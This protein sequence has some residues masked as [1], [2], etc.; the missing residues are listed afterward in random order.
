M[1]KVILDTNIYVDWLN[2]GLYEEFILGKDLARY[3]SAVVY[4]ELLAGATTP[5]AKRALVKL[6][7]GYGERVVAPPVGVYKRAGKL[8]RDLRTGGVSVRQA[9][10]VN[11]LLI[12][13]SARAIGATVVTADR[14]FETVRTFDDFALQM[15]PPVRTFRRSAS[16]VVRLFSFRSVVRGSRRG[17]CRR[18]CRG[19]TSARARRGRGLG[20]WARSFRR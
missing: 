11:D 14:D 9:S 4:M 10:L 5:A 16:T 7:F 18:G 8:L 17:G 15:S 2:R 3:L 12:A 1:K 19:R 20:L 13:M 6:V